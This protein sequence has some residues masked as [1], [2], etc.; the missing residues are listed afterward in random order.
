MPDS[1]LP[2]DRE[3]EAAILAALML[4]KSLVWEV[5]TSLKPEDM[6]L[7]PH[8]LILD[9][10][11]DVAENGDG[12]ID[13]VALRHILS[14]RKQLETVGGAAALSSLMDALPDIANVG[15]YVNI[16]LEHSLD[17][18]MR[19]LGQILSNNGSPP[20]DRAHAVLAEMY[21]A[22]AGEDSA[23]VMTMAE[24]AK[25]YES[26][27]AA[28]LQERCIETG[29]GSLDAYVTI[30]KKN[31]IVI[32]GNP[33]TGKSSLAMQIALNVMKTHHVLFISLEMSEEELFERVVQSMTGCSAKVIANP[34]HTTENNRQRIMDAAARVRESYHQLHMLSPGMV[35]PQDVMAHARSIQI[36]YGS[37]G[38]VVVDYLQLMHCPLKN[39]GTTER[40]TWLSRHMKA[41]ARQLNVPVMLLSQL[42]RD[43]TRGNR[44]PELHDLRDS[45]AIEQDADIVI[46]THRP[47]LEEENGVLLVRKQRHGPTGRTQ[48]NFESSRSRFLATQPTA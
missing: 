13:V 20:K 15:H 39:M 12:K 37:L 18:K 19:K 47:V 38:L 14:G 8:R 44:E 22:L 29:I 27:I 30:R 25:N 4:E 36:R 32:A 11:Y 10:M 17:R 7:E 3:A 42:S 26:N 48:V 33:S 41:I 5:M 9:A 16:V 43:N 45:G 35:T 40:V 1:R 31:Q 24:V 46:F 2:H 23:R 21:Q 34:S 28:G 6:Y